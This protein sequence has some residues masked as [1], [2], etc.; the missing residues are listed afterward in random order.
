[1]EK[2]IIEVEQGKYASVKEARNSGALPMVYYGK[3]VEPVQMTTDYQ[4]FRRAYKKSGRSSIVSL[5]LGGKKMDA[6][7]HDVQYHPVTDDMI[8]VDL[9]AVKAGQMIHTQIP[10]VFV[11]EAPA[12]KEMGGVFISNKTEVAVECLPKDLVHDIQV[13]ISSMKDFHSHL[14]IGDIQAPAGIKL[15]DAPDISIATIAPPRKEEVE[16]PVA[17]AA[18]SAAPAS[19][20]EKG[21]KKE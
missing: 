7:I 2:I 14:N 4:T 19:E 12:V 17:A 18:E 20:G 10:L 3:G 6:L 8:H 13:D 9:L 16:A 11:G 21:G 5:S 15:L 1:M